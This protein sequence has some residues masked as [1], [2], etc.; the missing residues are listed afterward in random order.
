[1][2]KK[3][4]EN[5]RH[6]SDD[7][8]NQIYKYALGRLSFTFKTYSLGSKLSYKMKKGNRHVANTILSSGSFAVR[9]WWPSIPSVQGFYT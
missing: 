4:W 2:K 1:M 5:V 7:Y 3:A 8:T 9:F 6:T